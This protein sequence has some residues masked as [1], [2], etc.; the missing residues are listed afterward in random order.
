MMWLLLLEIKKG[1]DC[2]SKETIHV[3]YGVPCIQAVVVPSK[4]ADWCSDKMGCRVAEALRSAN[5]CELLNIGDGGGGAHMTRLS[6][7]M[8][9]AKIPNPIG[10]RWQR[11]T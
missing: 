4:A 6:S 8:Q 2:S 10:W 9:D 7:P 3:Y 11:R 1:T 5:R